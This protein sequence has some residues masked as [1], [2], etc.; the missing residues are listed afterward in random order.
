MTCNIKQ[1]WWQ[2]LTWTL[3]IKLKEVTLLKIV[4]NKV[5]KIDI[6]SY[7]KSINSDNRDNSD[8]SSNINENITLTSHTTMSS[9]HEIISRLYLIIFKILIRISS[10]LISALKTFI[11][12][13]EKWSIS[14]I[15]TVITNA[16]WTSLKSINKN[17]NKR[18]TIRFLKMWVM[19]AAVKT[20]I[21]YWS[22]KFSEYQIDLKSS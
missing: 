18:I 4:N 8:S 5:S 12:E 9:S 15:K 21:N 19:N 16:N 22:I 1:I 6:N 3:V 14:L 13:N 2:V 11:N 10:I 20:A 7:S 17:K